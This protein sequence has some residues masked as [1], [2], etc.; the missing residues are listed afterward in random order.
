[1]LVMRCSELSGV[2]CVF[3]FILLL[4]RGE[5]TARC[6]MTREAQ[7]PAAKVEQATS[8]QIG[9]TIYPIR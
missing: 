7:E 1:M 9:S 3:S 4:W 2:W 6:T 5:F 8:A